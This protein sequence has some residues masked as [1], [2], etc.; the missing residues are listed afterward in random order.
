MFQAFEQFL[1]QKGAIKPQ[2]VPYY[3]KWVS[4]GYTFFDVTPQPGSMGIRG[5]NF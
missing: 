5:N 4:D 3:L 1:L 2:Y